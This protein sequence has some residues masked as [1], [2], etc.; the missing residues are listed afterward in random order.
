MNKSTGNKDES[1]QS[2]VFRIAFLTFVLLLVVTLLN[3]AYGI[4]VNKRITS[5]MVTTALEERLAV[6]ASVIRYELRELDFVGGIVRE[7]EQK[8]IYYLD[9]DKLRP[10]QVMLQTIASKHSL[11]EVFFLDE[12]RQLLVTN[13]RIVG[14]GVTHEPYAELVES[15]P[16]KASFERFSSAFF[17]NVSHLKKS[18]DGLPDMLTVMK[19]VVPIYHDM[20]DT[21][22]YVVMVRFVDGNQSIAERL[23][24]ST[25]F[26][27]VIYND[28]HHTILSNLSSAAV[29]YPQDGLMSFGGTSY[30]GKLHPLN[31]FSG[32]LLAEL[33]IFMDQTS[34][35]KQSRRQ[36]F[37][38]LLPL[39]VIACIALFLHF[40]M[41]KLRKSY[42]QLERSRQEAESA[43]IA[44]SEFLANMS[45]EIRTPL[46]AIVGL[47]GLVLKT[48][49]TEKQCDYM[50]K[51]K[52][53]SSVLLGIINN[54]L[55]FSKIEA[56][57]LE[58]ESAVF[59]CDDVLSN[60]KNI[61]ME[62]AEERGIGLFFHTNS[63]VPQLLKGDSMRIFQVLLNLTTNAI[64][65]TDTGQVDIR[66]D[67]VP[68]EVKNDKYL[69]L[70]F[71]V[72][73]SG[74]GLSK[75]QMKNLFDPF[76]QADS[77][78]TRKFG[79]TGLG[80][81]I[82]KE[83]VGIMGGAISVASEPDGGST[84]SFTVQVATVTESEV[85]APPHSSDERRLDDVRGASILLVEDNE[86]NQQVAAEY[87]RSEE[88]A[89]TVVDN[90]QKAVDA[91]AFPDL[92]T[93]FDLVLMDVQMPVMDGY[94][95]TEEIRNSASPYKNV[96]IIAM[97]AHAL[98]SQ[99]QQCLD[100][101]MND[102]VTKPFDPDV[103]FAVLVKWITPGQRV[104]EDAASETN[105]E[106]AQIVLPSV[107]PGLDLHNGLKRVA[108]NATL[109]LN[110]LSSFRRKF[111]GCEKKIV[112]ALQESRIDR[113]KELLHR[114]KGGAGNVGALELHQAAGE[115]ELA[116][117]EKHLPKRDKLCQNFSKELHIVSQSIQKLEGLGFATG[118]ESVASK[119][120]DALNSKKVRDCCENLRQLIVDD[121]GAAIDAVIA[122]RE[123]LGGTDCTVEV[124]RLELLLEEF[125]EQEALLC[126]DEIEKKVL[127]L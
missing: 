45:H 62:A 104:V 86:I 42:Q 37:N 84:F 34:L 113:A 120:T 91:V 110:L 72:E 24:E 82:C 53:S 76:T 127:E 75:D 81:T 71:S 3:G 57:M 74:I 23:A 101:G 58:I 85:L 123:M 106:E 26:P 115:L 22:G 60:V 10:I 63:N 13:D 95:A 122:L 52:S 87:L 28:N 102:H 15:M 99:R 97:T 40:L 92:H 108:G 69:L 118:T 17:N 43:N 46:N 25:G 105:N 77:S 39:A 27:F 100:A 29:P 109:Y 93:G 31:D 107:L 7:Q 111:V 66:V 112:C 4:V 51:I 70:H 65:F 56:G 8:I 54:I 126:L 103:L 44:K 67:I 18:V 30:V 125:K 50:M 78:T 89:V 12:D 68:G 73:D 124:D 1:P 47:G 16:G 96:P 90:G 20:G 21:Y 19:R 14:E 41:G 38:N 119:G 116:A 2:N 61:A 88:F 48:N 33:G 98:S 80:L 6:V 83:M 55:D 114:L 49:L 117:D 121:Y 94:T 36:V 35:V 32:S 9:F 11:D 79:G 64:K 59:R 5:S